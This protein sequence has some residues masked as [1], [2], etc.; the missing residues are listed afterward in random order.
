MVRFVAVPLPRL[1]HWSG[2]APQLTRIHLIAPLRVSERL[3]LLEL[4]IQE[5]VVP[6]EKTSPK[7]KVHRGFI[8]AYHCVR[9]FVLE[10]ADRIEVP[11]ITGHSLGGAIATIAAIDIQYNLKKTPILITFACPKIGN[12][13]WAIS[14]RNRLP[15]QYHFVNRWDI[16]HRLPFTLRH[17]V[18]TIESD[19]GWFDPHNLKNFAKIGSCQ[20]G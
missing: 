19:L 7:I 16:V 2:N 10:S 1:R 4:K 5:V 12:K 3:L 18:E 15:D 13:E 9:P 20:Y 8:E 6:F 11:I 17:P 14:G